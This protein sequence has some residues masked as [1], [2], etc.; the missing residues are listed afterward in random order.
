MGKLL[1]LRE[2]LLIEETPTI[3]NNQVT[4][5]ITD[6]LKNQYYRINEI[7]L[8]IL[9]Y[10]HLLSASEIINAIKAHDHIQISESTIKETQD[11]LIANELII[12][13]SEQGAKLLANRKKEKG[14][15]GPWFYLKNYLFFKV[16][17]VRPD[18]FIKKTLPF[19]RFIYKPYY[20][21]F[22]GL[23]LF[24]SLSAIMPRKTAFL[25]GFFTPSTATQ[26]VYL[27]FATLIIKI[28][29][30]LGHAYTTRKLNCQVGAFG[31]A[32]IILFP[33]L[34]TDTKN[35]WKLKNP[36]QRLQIDLSG[37][38][39]EIHIM[40]WC[41]FLWLV[42]DSEMAKQ[43]ITHIVFVGLISTLLI[44][45]NPL[46]RFDG[47][48]ALSNFLK[49]DNLQIQSYAL[50]TWK[51]RKMFLGLNLKKPFEVGS[52]K[53]KIMIFYALFAWCYRLVLYLSIAAV[54]YA[55]FFKTL[56]ILLAILEIILLVIRPL[57]KEL[58]LYYK[59]FKQ[60]PFNRQK[61]IF[62][63]SLSGLFLLLVIPWSST[64]IIPAVL[65]F[66]HRQDIY[67][68]SDAF[69]HH[70]ITSAEFVKKGQNIA[71]LS[72][73]NLAFKKDLLLEKRIQLMD[74]ISL[75]KKTNQSH[76]KEKDGFDLNQV[77]HQIHN[78]DKEIKRLN[79]KSPIDGLV[80]NHKAYLQNNLW[81]KK[82]DLLFS[83]IKPNSMIV[84]AYFP[85]YDLK[86][87]EALKPD[88]Y[89]LSNLTSMPAIAIKLKEKSLNSVNQLTS[90][91]LSSQYGGPIATD[92]AKEEPN[93]LKIKNSYFPITF[94]LEAPLPFYVEQR[95]VVIASVKRQ[96]LIHRFYQK[97]SALFISE[98][99]L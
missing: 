66:D 69:S 41:L 26:A 23:L 34:F 70:L 56:G 71:N 19:V 77:I 75:D 76:Y 9:N 12:I 68:S 73:D 49:I 98:S 21:W 10:W 11:F 44:N 63:S 93:E 22:L 94:N 24:F 72:S 1:P 14:N 28:F 7:T 51:L 5:L 61:L 91:Y 36:Y 8:K 67:V 88:A 2:D 48:Y 18:S 62:I 32:L 42:I 4:F 65:I 33:V 89:F 85:E 78:V 43:L 79:I 60:T 47:Y 81:Y 82:G 20:W 99:A 90:L 17:L 64:I 86:R 84:Y 52:Q 74:K 57:A 13:D 92:K 83:V 3:V 15:K 29:H 39:S 6:A 30:E 37:L 40:I 95:G 55:F 45:G 96:S 16:N 80:I 97:I 27:I 25:D 59:N 54:I 31:I 38:L 87:I 35:T 50:A 58:F 53:E 46:I